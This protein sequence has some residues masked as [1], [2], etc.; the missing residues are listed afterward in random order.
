MPFF[1]EKGAIGKSR[2]RLDVPVWPLGDMAMIPDNGRFRL[3]SRHT[4]R[5]LTTP[6]YE[7]T[8]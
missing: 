3:E 4:G 2:V 8:P 6:V 7:F 5:D 1:A